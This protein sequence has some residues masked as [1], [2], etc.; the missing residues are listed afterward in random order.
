VAWSQTGLGRVRRPD[1]LNGTET[2]IE[3]RPSGGSWDE[4]ADATFNCKKSEVIEHWKRRL[5][6]AGLG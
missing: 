2:N 4:A 1:T 3:G 6:Q 5:L